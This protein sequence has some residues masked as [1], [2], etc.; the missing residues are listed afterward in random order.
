MSIEKH[1]KF[2][3]LINS[4]SEFTEGFTT[5]NM[6]SVTFYPLRIRPHDS[7]D[8]VGLIQ[9]NCLYSRYNLAYSGIFSSAVKCRQ[10]LCPNGIF[11]RGLPKI[12]CS[13]WYHC[14]IKTWWYN[15]PHFLVLIRQFIYI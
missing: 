12:R 5:L 6:K 1:I 10:H 11:L 14:G 9:L 4:S 2:E 8:V 3:P 13:L 7:Y 15:L